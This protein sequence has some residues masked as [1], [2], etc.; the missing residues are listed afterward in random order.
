MSV[1][2]GRASDRVL[3]TDS[4]KRGIRQG[5]G[6]DLH[7]I[8]EAHALRDDFRRASLYFSN[9]I[10]RPKSLTEPQVLVSLALIYLSP[11]TAENQELRQCLSYF[12]PAYGYSS[13][14]HQHVLQK[15]RESC[16]AP[17]SSPP[18]MPD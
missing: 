13:P 2:P 6:A 4:W 17:S 9:G 1:G 15:V 3:T 18:T 5:A 7:W 14:G 8:R 16:D 10:C 11:D 12:F